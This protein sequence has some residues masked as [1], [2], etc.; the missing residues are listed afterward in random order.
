[1]LSYEF[2]KQAIA[3]DLEC[4]IFDEENPHSLINLVPDKIRPILYRVKDNLVKSYT[5][6]EGELRF[7][8]KPSESD[9]RLRLSF[10]DEYNR[11][12][13]FDK[14]MSMARIL[15]G[16]CSVERFVS[17]Y[18]NDDKRLC[19]IFTPPASYAS[20]IKRILMDSLDELSEI[21]K[22]PNRDENG[23]VDHKVISSKLKVFQLM[24]LRNNGGIAQNVNINQKSINYN[25]NVNDSYIN[26]RPIESY[27]LEELEKLKLKV[28]PEVHKLAPANVP[29]LSGF[30]DRS[31]PVEVIKE[32]SLNKKELV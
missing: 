17:R 30:S 22:L 19:W 1:M 20:T 12:T 11:A 14:K 10:W 15:H 27:S 23:R 25:Q 32:D 21:L 3:E 29:S 8:V 28:A 31:V 26:G 13:R 7:L 18:Q 4:S 24:D 2:R 6:D 16:V 5:T 9:D